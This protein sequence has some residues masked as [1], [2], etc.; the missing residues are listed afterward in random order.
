MSPVTTTH[1]PLASRPHKPRAYCVPV[2]RP[3]PPRP[4]GT[5]AA[6]TW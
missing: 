2:V 1:T 3:V 5:A 6:S 4:A